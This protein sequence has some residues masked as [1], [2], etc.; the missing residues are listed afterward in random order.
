[1]ANDRGRKPSQK[2]KAI[3]AKTFLAS[4]WALLVGTSLVFSVGALTFLAFSVRWPAAVRVVAKTASLQFALP[5]NSSIAD[6]L[7]WPISGGLL[8]RSPNNLTASV[9]P[10]K[11]SDANCSGGEQLDGTLWFRP[12]TIVTISTESRSHVDIQLSAPDSS[13]PAVSGIFR[14]LSGTARELRHPTR[15]VLPRSGKGMYSVTTFPIVSNTLRVGRDL[16]WQ[17]L[18]QTGLLQDG[19]VT[20]VRSSFVGDILFSS[21][22]VPLVLGDWLLLASRGNEYV[23]GVLQI[24]DLPFFDVALTTGR[25]EAL[26]HRLARN[27]QHLDT[28][29]FL[30]V[31][32]DPTMLVLWAI[33][34]MM[35][36]VLWRIREISGAKKEENR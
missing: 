17:S 9:K 21:E 23:Q 7:S 27:P 5:S 6:R 20:L 22:E 12:G 29:L 3:G 30:Q 8:C 10:T 34:V 2:I 33:V 14:D 18:A 15:I 35:V 36:D 1:M 32:K 24:N 16:P 28:P 31:I 25:G 19:K 13:H 4:R 26:L 11:A